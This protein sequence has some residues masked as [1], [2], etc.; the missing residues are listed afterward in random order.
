MMKFDASPKPPRAARKPHTLE[1]HGDQR[2]DPYYWLRDDERASPEVLAYLEEENRYAEAVLAPTAPLQQ[3]LYEEMVARQKPDESSVPYRY[4]GYWYVTRYQEGEEFPRY[5]RHK[6]ELSAPAQLLLDAN[7]RAR[8]AEYYELAGYEV[9]PD[10]RH[11]LVAEDWVSRRQYRLMVLDLTSGEWLDEQIENSSGNVVWAA[12]GTSFFYVR[13]DPETLRSCEVWW[14]RLGTPLSED[15]L[16]FAEPDES[17]YVA[18]EP[19]R[20]EQYLFISLDSTLTSE[21]WML[22]LDRPQAAPCCFLPRQRGHEY[23]VDHFQQRFYIRSNRDGNNFAL[24][25]SSGLGEAWQTLL[26]FRSQVLL[27]GFELFDSALV[28]E[29]REAGNTLL[30][31]LTLSGEEVRRVQF[32]DPAYVTWLGYNP[33]PQSSVLRY[34]YSSLTT[35]TSTFELDLHSGEQRLLKQQQ[36]IGRFNSGDY[37]SERLSVLAEDGTQVPV[38]LVYRRDR[39][40]EGQN[41][42]LIY[43]YGAYGLSEEPDFSSLRLSLLDRGF[44]FAIAHVRG[45]E[46]LG[47][48]WYESGRLL[49]KQNSFTDF[50]AVTRA[51]VAQGYGAAD[52]VFAEGGSAGGLLMGA[53]INMA[54]EL[55]CGVIAAVPFVDVLTSMLDEEMPL[56]AGEYDEWG[57]P[58]YR[59]YYDYIKAYSPYDQVAPRHYPHLLVVSGLHDS[60]V[61]YWEPAKWVAK[62]RAHKLDQH[63]LL[64]CMDMSAGHGGKSGRFNQLHDVAREYAFLLTLAGIRE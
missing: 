12:D 4:K 10:D 20:S 25:V 29:E 45:G 6:G 40:V 49:S 38:S 39:F 56:T 61:Q 32:A 44:V 36:V 23:Q 1:C 55:Y 63:L 53:V 35:P 50:I 48:H 26:P 28:V 42:L 17:F 5:E 57:D 62:L 16:I 21:S 54:P 33:E 13:Q 27:Q 46:E 51:L 22:P 8:D 31:Q 58:R 24:Y 47:R 9:S 15:R 43:G 7:A 64:L 3:Q 2:E 19:S 60:Q 14:H 37:C 41:P 18:I 30:R 11:L 59:E 52:K 34:G